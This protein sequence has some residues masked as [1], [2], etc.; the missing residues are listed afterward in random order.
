MKKR[1]KKS[2]LDNLPTGG[3]ASAAAKNE[4]PKAALP[5]AEELADRVQTLANDLKNLACDVWI[6]QDELADDIKKLKRTGH[7]ELAHQAEL[8]SEQLKKI[9][10]SNDIHEKPSTE[11]AQMGARERQADLN[12]IAALLDL[13]L[14]K[15]L[16][17]QPLSKFGSQQ[18]V[19]DGITVRHGGVDGLSQSNL[20]KKFAAAKRVL[21]SE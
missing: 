11:T 1:E 6:F 17:G 10:A 5:T 18:A 19:I 3:V 21:P 16:S 13:L 12:I 7:P 20:E 9:L 2:V 14:G 15:S 8:I 4:A